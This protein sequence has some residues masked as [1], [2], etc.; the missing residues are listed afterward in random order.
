V[1]FV[2]LGVSIQHALASVREDREI[3]TDHVGFIGVVVPRSWPVGA[4]AGDF[5]E[6]TVE[7]VDL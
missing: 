5:L 7:P 6:V 3:R 2:S 1:S 4:A